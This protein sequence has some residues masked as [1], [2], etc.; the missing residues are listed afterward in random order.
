MNTIM[1][2]LLNS[3][4][5]IVLFMTFCTSLSAVTPMLNNPRIG[6]NVQ[7]SRAELFFNDSD[8]MALNPVV[9][10][11]SSNDILEMAVFSPEPEDS[12]NTYFTTFGDVSF[13]IKE[14]SK[15]LYITYCHKP[16]MSRYYSDCMPYGVGHSAN[17]KGYVSS[18]G[19][20]ENI[21]SY[22]TE[23]QYSIAIYPDLAIITADGDSISNIECVEYRDSGMI[24]TAP[25]SVFQTGSCIREWYA[26]GYRYPLLIEEEE[27]FLNEE[28]YVVSSKQ[29]FW[30]N[31]DSQ[32]ELNDFLNEEIRQLCDY[33]KTSENGFDYPSYKRRTDSVGSMPGCIRWGEGRES[34]II[35]NTFQDNQFTE[36]LLCDIKGCVFGVYDLTLQE[37]TS[38][39]LSDLPMGVY[40]LALQS[41]SRPVTYKFTTD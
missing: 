22:S 7:Y 40:L 27:N 26:P 33:S 36:A 16:G 24:K 18:Y 25:D 15:R 38:I 12:L 2:I 1:R 37:H 17:S 13:E 6:D 28:G 10:K 41:P 31:Q 34:L 20:F 9:K 32:Y 4:F 14:D 30:C 5:L 19:V 11:V 23:S 3:L 8:T 35:S 21:G 29:S 39:R